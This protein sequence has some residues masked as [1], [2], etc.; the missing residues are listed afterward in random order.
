ME[1]VNVLIIGAGAVG[2]AVGYEI[3]R[4]VDDVVIAEM[5]DSFGRHTSSRNS[6]VIHSGIYYQQKSYKAEL[7]V[8]GNEL[9]YDYC[10]QNEVPHRRCTK[11]IVGNGEDDRQKLF[12]LM[13]NGIKNGVE[14][15]RLLDKQEIETLEPRI[16]ASEGLFVPSTGILDTHKYMESLVQ[17]FEENEGFIVYDMKVTEVT[18]KDYKYIV[19]FN[20]GEVFR[21]NYLINCAGL[22]CE[23]ISRMLGI[24]TEAE[25]LKIHWCKGEYY[26]TNAF[27]D[28]K[29]LIYP[30]PDPAGVFLGIHLTVN[31]NNEIR[32]GPNAY[33]VDSV[34]YKM[35]E[36]YKDEFWKA[37]NTYLKL[38]KNQ[39]HLD[40]VGV[41]P[42]LHTKEVKFRDFYIREESDKGLK[43]F[44][45]LM[46]IESPGLTASLAIA[47]KVAEMIKLD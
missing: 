23:S 13:E 25:N 40:D 41:R 1:D 8:R 2:L 14:G 5:E 45:N 31:L 33:Y 36:T 20:N 26:K 38:D 24:D 34:D 29:R 12:E 4:K 19:K 39:L 16:I 44:I 6:E 17:N 47:E 7:C 21:V 18:H 35:D 43:N 32:F 28:V 42:K 37:I 27:S 30:L 15:L 22:F 3:S 9:L 46:G 11:I 10:Q